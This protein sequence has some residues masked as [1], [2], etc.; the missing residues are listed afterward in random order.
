MCEPVTLMIAATALTAA[1]TAYTG[2]QQYQAGKASERAEKDA[3][4]AAQQK[5]KFDEQAHRERVRKMISSQRAAYG[6]SG[7]DLEGSPLLV[8]EDTAGQGELDALAIRYGGS[9]D[10]A[11]HR[12]KGRIYGKQG[13]AALVSSGISAGSSLLSGGSKYYDK[14]SA[15]KGTTG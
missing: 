3:A 7:V 14:K 8:L 11:Q 13:T 12:A 6:G 5:A 1:G 10:A 15:A 9:V 4:A 2:I